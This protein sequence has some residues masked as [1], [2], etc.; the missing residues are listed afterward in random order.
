VTET[1]PDLSVSIVTYNSQDCLEALFTSLASQEGLLWELFLVD[2]AS[3]DGTPG[4]LSQRGMGHVTTNAENAGFG[5]GHN[6]NGQRF[7]GRYLL[8]LNPDLELPPGLF[9]GLVRFL[10]NNPSIAIAGPKVLEGPSRTP[11]PPRRCYPGQML[12]PAGPEPAASQPAWINGCCMAIRRCVFEDIGG[13]DPA[14]FLYF[15][16]VDLCWRARRAGWQLGWLPEYEVLHYGRGS[17]RSISE[18]QQARELFAGAV[19]FWEKRYAERD[20]AAMLRVQVLAAQMLLA[21]SKLLSS[22]WP[23]HQGLRQARL[24]ARRDICREW[25]QRHGS[26]PWVLDSRCLRIAIRLARVAAD[27]ALSGRILFDDV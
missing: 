18:Y 4:I 15:E 9:A 25:L 21:A 12:M 20:Q 7:R 10:D 3:T 8:F 2:N 17:Q 24:R 27:W 14:Y 5:R 19:L 1:T 23:R 26:G 16:E 11:F 13:F 22:R 6:Q